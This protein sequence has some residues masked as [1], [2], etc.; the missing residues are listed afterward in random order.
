MLLVPSI[1]AVSA[2]ANNPYPPFCLVT[3]INSSVDP[4]SSSIRNAESGVNSRHRIKIR[5]AV[6]S[7]ITSL[8]YFVPR[9]RPS[10]WRLSRFPFLRPF[11]LL[12][13]VASGGHF[14]LSDLLNISVAG[15]R[16]TGGSS[17]VSILIPLPS[18]SSLF[19]DPVDSTDLDRSSGFHMPFF[20]LLVSSASFY[21]L[22]HS[23]SK[24]IDRLFAFLHTTI[25][26]HI[27]RF[28]APTDWRR[29][30]SAREFTFCLRN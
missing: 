3:S 1:F 22:S 23:C 4:R 10:L 25:F 26:I 9:S 11:G 28:L 7:E 24:V 29:P 5:A 8:P 6:C 19:Y 17:R 18:K 20:H 15:L 27:T 21:I 16:G 12:D 2:D 14:E 13:Q 30:S